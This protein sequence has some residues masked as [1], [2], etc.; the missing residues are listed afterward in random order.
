M[1]DSTDPRIPG[2]RKPA[3]QKP[4]PTIPPQREAER[5]AR[6][7]LGKASSRHGIGLIRISLSLAF[8][9]ET[10]PEFITEGLWLRTVEAPGGETQVLGM[11]DQPQEFAS[12]LV[13]A[14]T[15]EILAEGVLLSASYPKEDRPDGFI[16]E[17]N[18]DFVCGWKIDG[19]TRTFQPLDHDTMASLVDDVSPAPIVVE[20]EPIGS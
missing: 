7:V 14:L 9:L 8:R 12:F 11:G 3:P 15:S 6:T 19:A 18:P 1:P 13:A 20:V 2:P 16:A 5:L 4:R 10:G 17:P